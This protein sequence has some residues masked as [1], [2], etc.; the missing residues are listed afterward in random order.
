[1]TRP[2]GRLAVATLALLALPVFADHHTWKIERLYSNADGTLQF[3]VMHESAGADGESFLTGKTL[4]ST[5]SGVTKQFLFNH[6]LP[7]GGGGYYGGASPTANKR[8]LIATTG[9][10]LLGLVSPDYVIP[11]RFLPTEGA[12]LNFAGVDQF[13]YGPLPTDGVNALLRAGPPAVNVAV[14][15]ASA[16]ATI[17]TRPIAAVEFY[18]AALDH[19]FVSAL[20]PDIDALESGRLAGW[21][22]T[23]KSFRVFA[24]QADG[25]AGVNPVCRYYIPPPFGDSHFFSASPAEC[26]ATGAKF[27]QFSFESPSVFYVALPDTTTGACPAGTTPVYRVWN[28]RADS[29]HRYTSDRA[30][31]DQMLTMG[32]VAEGYGP[33]QV[34]MCAA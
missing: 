15:F 25:G 21:T 6:D 31:R 3:I 18:N 9:V 28:Q 2:F 19:Y 8:L 13:A 12:T 33:D 10:A 20:A 23:A 27:P 24:T 26:T 11:D 17:P 16:S 22:A 7:G 14:N 29:N 4:T 34:I 30:L 1:M 32:Y 5:R